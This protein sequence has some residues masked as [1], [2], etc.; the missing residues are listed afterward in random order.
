MTRIHIRQGSGKRTLEFGDTK[1]IR[2]EVHV[3]C[4]K[5][6]NVG[7]PFMPSWA[8]DC[9]GGRQ[10]VEWVPDHQVNPTTHTRKPEFR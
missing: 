1:V 6:V 3:R 7:T 8:Y 10:R 9:S 5:M 2:G 4:R